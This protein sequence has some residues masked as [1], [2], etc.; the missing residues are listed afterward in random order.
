MNGVKFDPEQKEGLN[1][2]HEHR[3]VRK[4]LKI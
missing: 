3:P 2:I 4:G 1:S